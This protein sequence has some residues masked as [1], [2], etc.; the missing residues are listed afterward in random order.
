MTPAEA[1]AL[2]GQLQ[3]G[4]FWVE[5]TEFLREFDEVTVGF[6]L[7]ES[8][9]L[10]SLCSGQELC[11][12]QQLPGAW[13]RGQSAGGC[14]NHSG[15]PSNP[16]FWLRVS[17]PS[18]VYVALLQQPGLRTAGEDSVSTAQGA[19]STQ[20]AVGLHI[21]KVTHPPLIP[22]A[23]HEVRHRVPETSCPLPAEVAR[24]DGALSP[25][26]AP[27]CPPSPPMS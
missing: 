18:E 17:E 7:S 21:W 12:T 19:G 24:I 27:S 11:H 15:F 13:V 10:Q 9:H 5:E 25:P 4:E 26:R 23:H 20:Q 6:P 3:A 8:G 2:L 16:K 14:R 1:C 22:L